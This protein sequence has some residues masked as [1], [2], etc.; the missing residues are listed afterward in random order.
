MLSRSMNLTHIASWRPYDWGVLD[1]V[2]VGGVTGLVGAPEVVT[3]DACL[4]V[5]SAADVPGDRAVDAG[6]G[7]GWAMMPEA[8]V[9]WEGGLDT[10]PG[11]VGMVARACLAGTR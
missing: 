4:G 11:D 9:R 7:E 10:P 6:L 1:V 8:V 2:Q 3:Q 5:Q